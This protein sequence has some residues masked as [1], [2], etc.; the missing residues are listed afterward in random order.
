MQGDFRPF[1]LFLSLETLGIFL[2][3]LKVQMFP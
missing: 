3:R 2:C 1:Y